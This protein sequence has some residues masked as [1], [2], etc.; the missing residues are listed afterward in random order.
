MWL[1]WGEVVGGMRKELMPKDLGSANGQL[2][3]M[4]SASPLWRSAGRRPGAGLLVRAGSATGAP[5]RVCPMHTRGMG[6]WTPE[7]GHGE[8]VV[9]TD[10]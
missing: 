2:A 3:G 4:Y 8:R 1:R 6:L 7:A 9:E 5:K 10:A